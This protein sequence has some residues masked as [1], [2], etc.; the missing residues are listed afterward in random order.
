MANR[1]PFPSHAMPVVSSLRLA[2]ELR[3]TPRV[4]LMVWVISCLSPLALIYSYEY[5]RG[6]SHALWSCFWLSRFSP[7]PFA[8][9]R[10]ALIRGFSFQI[11]L[12]TGFP[13]YEFEPGTHCQSQTVSESYWQFCHDRNIS[14]KRSRFH[15]TCTGRKPTLHTTQLRGKLQYANF[16]S[17]VPKIP[18]SQ[19]AVNPRTQF[20]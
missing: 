4:V 9:A 3:L 7:S 18:P 11:F 12:V 13:P 10:L 20:A 2:P 19:K 16:F 15:R 5:A 17:E 6:H 1:V 8:N 14:G